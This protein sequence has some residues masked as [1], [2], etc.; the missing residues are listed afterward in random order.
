M[1]RK[2]SDMIII[3]VDFYSPVHWSFFKAQANG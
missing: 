3:G 2:E 1:F